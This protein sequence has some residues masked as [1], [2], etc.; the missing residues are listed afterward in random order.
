[1]ACEEERVKG[2][3]EKPRAII[4]L[5]F[6]LYPLQRRRRDLPGHTVADFTFLEIL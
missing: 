1:V 4:L 3:S 2:E 6:P 5:A